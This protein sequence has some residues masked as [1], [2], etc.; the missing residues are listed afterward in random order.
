MTLSDFDEKAET[1]TKIEILSDPRGSYITQQKSLGT[2][3]AT[4]LRSYSTAEQ[5]CA[6]NRLT[7]YLADINF[8]AYNQTISECEELKDRYAGEVEGLQAPHKEACEEEKRII[9]EWEGKLEEAKAERERVRSDQDLFN[10]ISDSYAKDD[11]DSNEYRTQESAYYKLKADRARI[12]YDNAVFNVKKIEKYLK[13]LR[14][15]TGED[16]AIAAAYQVEINKYRKP[17]CEET[18]YFAE[19]QCVGW[20]PVGSFSYRDYEYEGVCTPTQSSFDDQLDRLDIFDQGSRDEFNACTGT[21]FS[22]RVPEDGFFE[23]REYAERQRFEWISEREFIEQDYF[24]PM[25]EYIDISWRLIEKPVFE[26][27]DLEQ[28]AARIPK[29]KIEGTVI[30]QLNRLALSYTQCR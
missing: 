16:C 17:E 2:K 4:A 6:N 11:C 22:K 9:E 14:T 7:F 20:C 10:A 8:A 5:K 29:I 26:R 21:R 27:N 15:Q 30:T 25:K 1:A 23:E 19:P 18:T 13:Y 28:Q 3:L 12:A 24:S